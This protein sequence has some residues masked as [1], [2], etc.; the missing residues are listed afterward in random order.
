MQRISLDAFRADTEGALR[1][2]AET[3]RPVSL[4]TDDVSAVV[5]AQATFDDLLRRLDEAEAV[6]GIRRGLDQA[7]RGE[8]RDARQVLAAIGRRLAVR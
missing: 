1:R 2:I 3:G 8:G 4:Q 7:D 6:A 5:L